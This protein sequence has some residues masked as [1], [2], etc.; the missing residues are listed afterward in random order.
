M[1][2]HFQL[3]RF[4]RT[5]TLENGFFFVR[6]VLSS[7]C[8]MCLVLF[9][10][11]LAGVCRLT[12]CLMIKYVVALLSSSFLLYSKFVWRLFFSSISLFSEDGFYLNLVEKYC[13]FR[14]LIHETKLKKKRHCPS[15][16]KISQFIYSFIY[17]EGKFPKLSTLI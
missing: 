10:F 5:F 1:F 13:Y 14:M 6:C 4:F 3:K 12:L 15:N 8:S 16:Y 17:T 7:V 2:D 11:L 9:F